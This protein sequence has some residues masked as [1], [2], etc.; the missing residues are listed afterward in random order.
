[1]ARV[2]VN[3]VVHIALH[4]AVM[5]IGRG[6]CMAGRACEGFV[7]ARVGVASCAYSVGAAVCGIEPCVVERRSSPYD[8]CVAG[9]TGGGESRRN[10]VRIGRACELR[11][12]AGVAVSRRTGKHIVDV[13]AGAGNAYVRTG[14]WEGC[15][16]VVEYGSRPRHC[17]VT[18]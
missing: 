4:A 13:A 8:G 17:R 12:V 15:V 16:V 10:V 18:G 6:L 9:R 2:A 14:Q 7:I 3:A 11:L 1:M 5:R